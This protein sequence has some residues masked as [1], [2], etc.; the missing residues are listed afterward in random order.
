MTPLR[1]ITPAHDKQWPEGAAKYPRRDARFTLDVHFSQERASCT[2]TNG[3]NLHAEGDQVRAAPALH[4][5]SIWGL[6]TDAGRV[7]DLRRRVEQ[8]WTANHAHFQ[9]AG[10]F[11]ANGTKDSKRLA[12]LVTAAF[13]GAPP[14][15]AP[16]ERF[17]D[18][19]VA[20]DRDTLLGS[21]DGLLENL[22]KRWHVN[23]YKSTYLDVV[24]ASTALRV[25]PRF[26]VLVCRF[27]KKPRS[28]P[29]ITSPC[30]FPENFLSVENLRAR[31]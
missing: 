17:P 26:N 18:G 21:G 4:F 25:N 12:R 14:D 16:S 9:Y 31:S 5:V 28:T 22:G 23:E 15:T 6:R 11:R 2:V 10:I 8:E 7:E 19:Q 27:S 3:G 13:N 29:R 1:S 24:E 30:V 20:T